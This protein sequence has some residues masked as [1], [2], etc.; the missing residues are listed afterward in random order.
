M[1]TTE[2]D[3]ATPRRH[4][5]VAPLRLV[6]VAAGL[7]LLTGATLPS[8]VVPTADDVD[9]VALRPA[10]VRTDQG[11]AA[12]DLVVGAALTDDVV[13]AFSLV[14]AVPGAA[15]EVEAGEPVD[16]ATVTRGGRVRPGE[17]LRATVTTDVPTLLVA[18]VTAAGSADG[19]ATSL[20]ALVLPG[21]AGQEPELT[22]ETADDRATGRI[23]VAGPLLVSV[24]LDAATSTVLTDRLVLPDQPLVVDDAPAAWLRPLELVVTDELGRTVRAT[25][26]AGGLV[27]VAG[28]LLVLALAAVVVV[29]RRA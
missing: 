21:A 9:A 11:S 10:V 22:L 5:L 25:R 18:E 24:R 8:E 17:R 29:R 2:Q 19:D 28:G 23:E 14:A 13:V 16:A 4:R 20:S 6:A 3:P 12:V 7:V 15:G 1:T 26:G 27:A